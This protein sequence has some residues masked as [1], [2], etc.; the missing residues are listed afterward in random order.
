MPE[1]IYHT[2]F[3]QQDY[4][5][6][7][8]WEFAQEKVEHML[9]MDFNHI[10]TM[11]CSLLHNELTISALQQRRTRATKAGKFRKATE[12]LLAIEAYKAAQKDEVKTYGSEFKLDENGDVIK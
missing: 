11:T 1:E 8:H 7:L 12:I 3:T 2:A 9:N 6:P 10:Y 5:K 4:L